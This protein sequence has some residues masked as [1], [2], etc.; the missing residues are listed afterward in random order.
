MVK[1]VDLE[2][3]YFDEA[4]GDF[5]DCKKACALTGAGISVESGIPDFRSPGGLWSIFDPQEYAT[6]QAFIN[7]LEKAW[8]LY[9]EVAKTIEPAEPNAAHTGL[10]KL[11][12]KGLLK[13]VITQNI[14]NLHQK[15]GS[16]N[17]IEVHGDH[18]HLHCLKC[19]FIRDINESDVTS[20]DIPKC[21]NCDYPLKPNVVLFGEPIKY[22]SEIEELINGC[23]CLL[24]VGTSAQ[25]YPVAG[26]PAIVKQNNG[27]IFEFNLE[28]TVLTSGMQFGFFPTESITDYFFSGKASSTVGSFAKKSI[29]EMK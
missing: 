4:V 11:E 12:E 14:D 26:F 19:S 29:E 28:K 27:Y 13:G 1:K 23:D 8:K 6:I 2:N 7:T 16:K 22:V 20:E 10:A 3:E 5:L 17:V 15:G 9:R 25:V 21:E 18:Q 24:I